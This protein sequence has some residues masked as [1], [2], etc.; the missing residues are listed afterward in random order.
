MRYHN[1]TQADES[2]ANAKG[3]KAE[4]QATNEVA[5]STKRHLC[6]TV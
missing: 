1:K 4:S 2:S 3:N 6:R 5:V